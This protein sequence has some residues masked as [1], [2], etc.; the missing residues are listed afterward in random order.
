MDPGKDLNNH[1]K[2]KRN[3]GGRKCCLRFCP[4]TS[5]DV[6]VHK[7]PQDPTERSKWLAFVLKDRPEF[8]VQDHSGICTCHFHPTCY[9]ARIVFQKQFNL[10]CGHKRLLKGSIPTMYYEDPTAKKTKI[11]VN[12][13]STFFS[14]RFF[15]SR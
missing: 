8:Q 7:F 11:Q 1:R 9:P 13:V 2:R 15:L 12:T 10:K 6:V 5:F 14:S 3:S 4:N